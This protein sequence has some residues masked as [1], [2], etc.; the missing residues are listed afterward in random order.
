[1][2]ENEEKCINQERNITMQN[3]ERDA[4]R[5]YHASNGRFLFQGINAE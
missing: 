5:L 4:R 2:K 1:M 3:S